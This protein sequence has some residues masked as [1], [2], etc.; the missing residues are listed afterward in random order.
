MNPAASSVQPVCP[1]L[2]RGLA[3]LGQA[4]GLP[5]ATLL[6]GRYGEDFPLYRAISQDS[7]DVMARRVAAYR[8]EGYRRFQLKGCINGIAVVVF[9][10]S[11]IVAWPQA[12]TMLQT[13][14]GAAHTVQALT[15][16]DEGP[17]TQRHPP[18]AVW[19]PPR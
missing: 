18:G 6:G 13:G 10:I 3:G 19:R 9:V 11:G 5:V 16:G 12:L 7:P 17:V 4:A 14:V 8:S 15:A 2:F 1:E